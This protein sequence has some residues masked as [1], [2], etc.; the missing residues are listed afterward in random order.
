MKNASKGDRLPLLYILKKSFDQNASVNYIV[1]QD[2][3]REKR[4]AALMEYSFEMCSM[5]G[6]IFISD[7]NKACALILNQD[8]KEITLS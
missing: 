6:E 2:N 3:Q 1:N 5:F 8:K 4:I 7:D